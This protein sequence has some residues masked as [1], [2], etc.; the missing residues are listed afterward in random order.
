[1][2]LEPIRTHAVTSQSTG[3]LLSGNDREPTPGCE[4]AEKRSRGAGSVIRELNVSRSNGKIYIDYIKLCRVAT[5]RLV[6]SGA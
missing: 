1:V 6:G 2:S 5:A 3:V 4:A